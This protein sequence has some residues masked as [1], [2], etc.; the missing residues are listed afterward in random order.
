MA[1]VHTPGRNTQAVAE[2][3]IGLMLTLGRRITNLDAC[4]KEGRWQM[5]A[6][7]YIQAHLQ[8]GELAGKTLGILGLGNIGCKVAQLACAFGMRVLAY[9]P[10]IE[11]SSRE[12][13]NVTLCPSVERDA[14]NGSG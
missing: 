3:T 7:P 11:A 14:G 5:P 2:L 10:Y 1:V 13:R 12:C 8:A 4:V 6:E 9:D